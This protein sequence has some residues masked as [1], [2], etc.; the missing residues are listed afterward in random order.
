MIGR[1]ELIVVILVL[2]VLFGASRFPNIMRN[3]AEGINEFKKGI[4]GSGKKAPP[5]SSGG[6]KRKK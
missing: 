5:K 2:L 6:G 3:F 1:G 4:K